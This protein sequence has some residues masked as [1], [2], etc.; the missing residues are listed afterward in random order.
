MT[1]RLPAPGTVRLEDGP[2]LHSQR[3][4]QEYLLALEPKR[5]LAPFLRE[6]GLPA[7]AEPYGNWESQ[8]LDGHTAGHYLSA[9]SL[10][11]AYT[12]DARFRDRAEELVA[13]FAAAQRAIGTGY[14]GGVPQSAALWAEVA[15]G[16]IR[17]TTFTQDGRWVPWYNLHKTFAGL[18][19]A[20]RSAHLEGALGVVTRLADW[21]L[22][23]AAR[24][25]DHDFELMLDTEFGGMNESFADLARITGRDDHLAMA[26]RFSHRAILEP[27][28]RGEDRLTG[29][30]ANTQ[31]PKVLG[32]QRVA[33]LTGEPSYA[34]AA[35][36]FF[37]TVA[38]RRSTSIGGHGVR[39]HFHAPDDFHAMTEDREGP[40]SC[41]SYN[42]VR[43]AGDLYA[44][45]GDAGYLD[46][47]ERTLHNHVLSA[48]HPEHG[49]F[50]YFTPMRPD[51]YRV[52][53]QPEN[54]F[55]CCVG[56]GMEAHAR[57]AAYLYAER[58]GRLAVNLFI[59]SSIEW[60]GM[61]VT[62]RATGAPVFG[63][64][65]T[66][67][68]AHPVRGAIDVRV[69][70]WVEGDPRVTVNGEPFAASRADGYL[71]VEREWADG[72]T[73]VVV[74]PASPRF[75]RLAD[76]SE[77]V[78][79]AWGPTVYAAVGDSDD[80]TGLLADAGRMSHIARGSLAPLTTAP[81]V[82]DTDAGRAMT[83]TA[84]GD[85]VL[86]TDLG[87]VTLVPFA[88]V[89][90]ARYTL[91]FP[92][93][94]DAEA[95]RGQLRD[96]DQW[97]LGVD[98]RTQDFI[99][100]GEQQ[101][102]S[103]HGFRGDGSEAGRDGETPWRRTS[104]TMTATL[105]DWKRVARSVRLS[106]L[107]GDGNVGYELVAN[108]IP[109][110]TIAREGGDISPVVCTEEYELPAELAAMD[111]ERIEL[112]VRAFAG[113]RTDRITELRL[114]SAAPELAAVGAQA[115]SPATAGSESSA[116]AASGGNS[117][118]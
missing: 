24:I 42:M 85:I 77:W 100:L 116:Q 46:Y 6:A 32:Y 89:H 1:V 9:T 54:S 84:D 34:R 55:W 27:L 86:A 109:V 22:G 82:A 114:L 106:W 52:Y 2:F 111:V 72:D 60:R 48:Q 98:A 76:G 96:R 95:R 78:S 40:E 49:G 38:H 92:V 62:Q 87:A 12:G 36:F 105:L 41:N 19:E 59:D 74:L 112:T 107:D 43:L 31:I 101:P 73:L 18:I 66:V 88:R 97:Q 45:T 23:L 25:D 8:G 13:G 56:T 10:M 110:A 61:T 58:D 39:E 11:F 33:E 70:S 80:L 26:K 35:S 94:A 30:H 16:R 108:G 50:V 83:G 44:D 104:T 71:S 113:R 14:L 51:H 64:E 69:P 47:I 103:D 29:L 4:D 79:V 63:A 21:W 20:H 75:E 5:L 118:G 28:A 15:T 65:L 99:T 7:D 17:P 68:A 67:S 37:D 57:H 90:D 53:S 91:Y 81:I 3:L 115:A 102:E 117:A 93:G